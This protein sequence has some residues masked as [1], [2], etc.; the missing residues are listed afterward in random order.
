MMVKILTDGGWQEV[1][2]PELSVGDIPR[3]CGTCAHYMD[4]DMSLEATIKR[5]RDGMPHCKQ[6]G[7]MRG[8]ESEKG[9]FIWKWDGK[10]RG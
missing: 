9:C 6:T 3:K 8:P 2:Q 10:T 4:E 7:K 1:E 5:K